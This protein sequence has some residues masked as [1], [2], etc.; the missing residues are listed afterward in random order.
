MKEKVKG[1]KFISSAVG[2]ECPKCKTKIL[3]QDVSIEKDI[4]SCRCLQCNY[5]CLVEIVDMVY[6]PYKKEEKND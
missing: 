1:Y 4:Y 5:K 2:Y 3:L 6:R